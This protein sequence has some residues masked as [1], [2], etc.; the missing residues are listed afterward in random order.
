MKNIYDLVHWIN[1]ILT[2]SYATYDADNDEILI[3][4]T[5]DDE[6]I[7]WFSLDDFEL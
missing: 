4:D 1:S 6:V 2:D 3:R 7:Y 5:R